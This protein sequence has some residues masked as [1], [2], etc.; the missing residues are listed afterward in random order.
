MS[1]EIIIIESY[2][3]LY[4]LD[5]VNEVSENRIRI[6]DPNSEIDIPGS[7]PL[8][9]RVD[10]FEG[11]L[12]LARASNIPFPNEWENI[13]PIH[14]TRGVSV[15]EPGDLVFVVELPLYEAWRML[16]DAGISTTESN[17]H[18]ELKEEETNIIL[19]IVWNTLSPAQ[20]YAAMQLCNEEPD[21]W[22]HVS[23]QEH[24]D[25]YEAL[26]LDWK[27]SREKVNPRQVRNYVNN[28]V[29]KLIKGRIKIGP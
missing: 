20:R 17:A 26:Y 8:A 18:F 9:S 10:P 15:T 19:G 23:A 25:G 16:F 28:R 27:I 14:K 22:K 3:I 2:D 12:S 24:G 21:K 29:Q 11:R 4:T 13:P 5:M 6:P 1:Q 7:K